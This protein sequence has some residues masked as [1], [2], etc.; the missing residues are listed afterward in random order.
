MLYRVRMPV[1]GEICVAP[2]PRNSASAGDAAE[3]AHVVLDEPCDPALFIAG[4]VVCASRNVV[5]ALRE[6]HA[7]GFQ[8][9]PVLL[10]LNE[11]Y[12]VTHPGEAASLPAG[13]VELVITGCVALSRRGTCESW[14][15]DD[16]A[17]TRSGI[18]VV[19][20]RCAERIRPI[21]ECEGIVLQPLRSATAT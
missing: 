2:D 9:R 4:G 16:V 20:G 19:S 12:A 1:L 15:G 13:I 18:V 6:L 3:L 17:R 21:V 10:S 14:S 11:Q 7:T 8:I 5:E